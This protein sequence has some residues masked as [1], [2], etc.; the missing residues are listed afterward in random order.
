MT[1]AR[2]SALLL[3]VA[4]ALGMAQPATAATPQPDAVYLIAAHQYNL[5]I[6]LAAHAAQAKEHS[7]CLQRA[8]A[9]IESDHRNLAAQETTL[10]QRFGIVLPTIPTRTQRLQ[11][12]AL[13]A[14]A[15]TSGYED[16]WLVLQRQQHQQYL[17]LVQGNVPKSASPA[18]ESVAEGAQPVIQMDLRM[19]AGP[20]KVET[21]TPI[22]PTGDGGQIADGRR[23]ASLI[24]MVLVGV[25]MILLLVG[26]A[27]SAR[28][29]LIG[30]AAVAVGLLMVF[31]K[32]PDNSGDV[33]K[34][35]PT[36]V[37]R[38]VAVPPVKVKLPGVANA[39][40][41]PVAT[42]GDGQLQV[43]ASPDDVGWWAA[44]ASPGSDDGTVLLVGHVDSAKY[45][46]GVFAGLSEVPVGAAVAVTGGDGAV[47]KYRIVARRT[48][49]Q[50]ALPADLFR[51]D[52]KPRLALVTC[53][54]AYDHKNHR[55]TH[56][57]VLYGV[58]A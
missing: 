40:V 57:L 58:P 28:R 38:E 14:K 33:P 16:A 4:G 8:G 56:N 34:A 31:G 49:D 46:R 35:A 15:G 43:P 32:L 3:V 25:G 7:A 12:T 55:Y 1:I 29:R 37:A 42:A 23:T 30:A 44:G 48:Y 21:H 45:G 10:A 50:K 5:T 27:G 53:I 20:C 6:I 19:V 26:K 47:H 13:Q 18:V 11:L 24:A 2:L 54:G 52:V 17:T 36:P 22:V 9:Q 51:G 41:L 39:A